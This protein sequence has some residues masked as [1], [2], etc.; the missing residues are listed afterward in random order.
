MAFIEYASPDSIP[1]NDRV[2]DD[3]NIIQIHSVHP[4]V[5]KLHHELY[6]ELM[7][8]ASPLSRIERE[9]VAVV[10]SNINACHY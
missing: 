9:W 10:A 5:M 3:D 7:H 1:L 6:I 4:R 8:R 2:K